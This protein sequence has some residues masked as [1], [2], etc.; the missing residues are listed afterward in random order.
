MGLLVLLV[1]SSMSSLYILD[2]NPLS[3]VL[4]ANKYLLPFSMLFFHF[5]KFPLRY[6]SFL[7]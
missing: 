3:V 4:L 5:A 2:I 1:L 7:L 6:K